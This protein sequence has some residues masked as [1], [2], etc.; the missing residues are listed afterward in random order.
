MATRFLFAVYGILVLLYFLWST[1][2]PFVAPYFKL[3]EHDCY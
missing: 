2:Y 1:E 3:P